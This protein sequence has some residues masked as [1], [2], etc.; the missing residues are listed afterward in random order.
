MTP[1]SMTDKKDYVVACFGDK[2]A[3]IGD[4]EG[5]PARRNW[6]VRGRNWMQGPSSIGL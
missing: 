6:R 4:K 5:N 3:L 1:K 2:M